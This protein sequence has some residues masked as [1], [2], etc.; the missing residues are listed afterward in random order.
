VIGGGATPG[1][2][3]AGTFATTTRYI[4]LQNGNGLCNINYP[5]DAS[6][7]DT[8]TVILMKRWTEV[9]QTYTEEITRQTLNIEVAPAAPAAGVGAEY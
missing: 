3:A 6:G 9:G 2:A 8:I 5:A 1:T 4:L 7:T